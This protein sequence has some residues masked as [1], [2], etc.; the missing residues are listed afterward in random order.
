MRGWVLLAATA[1]LLIAPSAA[2]QT[3]KVNTPYGVAEYPC[4]SGE[5]A[6]DGGDDEP[7][8][9][10][11]QAQAILGLVGLVGSATA[12]GYTVYRVRSRRRAL[13]V[14]LGAIERA[15]LDAKSDTASGIAKLSELRASVRTQHEK[16]RLDDAHFLELDKRATQY[17]VKLR[18]LEIDRRFA[19]MPPLLLAEIRR[20]LA[21]GVLSQSEADIIEVRAAAYR[22]PDPAR[23]ELSELVRG[24]ANTD[25]PPAAAAAAPSA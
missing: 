11:G 16:G 12:G 19:T 14:T 13:T 8:W 7:W 10:S 22:I 5:A 24:W 25:A 21:D 20:L 15:Y 17:L 3:C 6:P 2:A 4:G 9:A 1:A 23:A 18:L